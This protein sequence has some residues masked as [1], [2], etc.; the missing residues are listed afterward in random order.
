MPSH[1]PGA[2]IARQWNWEQNIPSTA[3]AEHKA[4]QA[5]QQ[6]IHEFI[7]QD[8]LTAELTERLAMLAAAEAR[9]E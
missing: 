5:R 8:A 7:R 1:H 9:G 4:A 6:A 2:N 3:E